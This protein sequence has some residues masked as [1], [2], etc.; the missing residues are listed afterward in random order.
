MTSERNQPWKS[1]R[2]TCKRSGLGDEHGAL[3]ACFLD[4]AKFAGALRRPLPAA[5]PGSRRCAAPPAAAV[6]VV[7]FLEVQRGHDNA[8]RLLAHG[9]AAGLNGNSSMAVVVSG[10]L[11]IGPRPTRSRSSAGARVHMAVHAMS[12]SYPDQTLEEALCEAAVPLCVP[13]RIRKMTPCSIK[14][15]LGCSAKTTLDRVQVTRRRDGYQHTVFRKTYL[16][17]LC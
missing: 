17:A 3:Y 9:H 16:L 11:P 5:R 8:E 7:L 2:Q 12:R 13:A 10:Y 6:T 14:N 4:A 1:I 15:G